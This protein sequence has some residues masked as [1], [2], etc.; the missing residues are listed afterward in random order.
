MSVKLRNQILLFLARKFKLRFRALYSGNILLFVIGKSKFFCPLDWYPHKASGPLSAST[1]N[2]MRGK[3]ERRLLSK[4]WLNQFFYGL[5]FS[6]NGLDLGSK[7]LDSSI[8][9]LCYVV[10]KLL[11]S[12]QC[13]K[14]P[15]KSL[16]LPDFSKAER[17]RPEGP[18]K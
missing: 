6:R 17:G 5:P 14:I 11:T 9:S 13:W 15:I 8:S 7:M 12:S 1:K 2:D 16:N 18:T 3:R 4:L 10:S